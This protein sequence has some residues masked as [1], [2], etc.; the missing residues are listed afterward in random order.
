MNKA[1]ENLWTFFKNEIFPV[2]ST[3]TVFNQYKDTDKKYDMPRAAAIRRNNLKNYLKSFAVKPKVLLVGEA[4]G[5]W[6]C[7]FSGIPFTSEAQLVKNILP[8]NGKQSST[9]TPPYSENSASIF[10]KILAPAHQRFI[11]W[12]LIPYHPHKPNKPLSI[13]NPGSG[14]I[15][16]FSKPLKIIYRLQ[17][18][19]QTIAIGRKAEQA[20]LLIDVPYTYVRH[21]S[22]A[23]AQ[24]FEEG[25]SKLLDL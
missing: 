24:A 22:Q 8:F 4:A 1:I 16:L 19:E 6:G 9:R 12:N 18:P 23:G 10:W 3:E 13:R 25:I 15:L 7:R 17:Q 5:P 11:G 20:L 2:D 14:E 21:P